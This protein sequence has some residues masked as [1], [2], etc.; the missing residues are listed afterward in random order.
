MNT[1]KDSPTRRNL[2]WV[3]LLCVLA[4]LLTA[5]GDSDDGGS[6]DS[7]AAGDSATATTGAPRESGEGSTDGF[8]GDDDADAGFE[9]EEALADQEEA[10]STHP[11]LGSGAGN[12]ASVTAA[13]IGRDIVFTA[14]VSVVSDDVAAATQAAVDAI[15]PLGGLIFGQD[16]TTDPFDRTVLTI[17]VRPTEFSEALS[18]LGQIG[19][20]RDQSISAEDV[21]D[22]VVDLDSRIVTATASVDRLRGFLDGATNLTDVAALERELQERE[23]DLELLRGQRRTIEDAVSLATITLTITEK[24]V[25]PPAAAIEIS[26]GAYIGHDA[27]RGCES[28]SQPDLDEDNQVT[29]CYLVTNSGE[30]TLNDLVVTDSDRTR[31]QRIVPATADVVVLEPGAST[32]F[33]VELSAS[34]TSLRSTARVVATGEPAGDS[35]GE[36]AA[37][38]AEIDLFVQEDDSLPSV[39][40]VFSESMSRTGQVLY[41][42]LLAI[43]GLSPLLVVAAIAALVVNRRRKPETETD[44]EASS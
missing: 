17:K 5:C 34:S 9:A 41:F 12:S 19:E 23:Q 35:P 32:T 16:T 28:A 24:V 44:A 36:P 43:V 7:A 20:L 33:F 14:E 10:Q 29:L 13:D 4:I 38:L 27:G 22:R 11:A 31:R 18:R 21:T 25:S 40:T 15:A 42:V 39:G 6:A 30:V 8:G 37:A 3:G 2:V 1:T 26:V